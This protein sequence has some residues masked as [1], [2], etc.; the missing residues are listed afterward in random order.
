MK[1][2][3]SDS[4]SIIEYRDS[5]FETILLEDGH[6]FFLDMHLNRLRKAGKDILGLDLDITTIENFIKNN[7]PDKGIFGLRIV[8]SIDS[9][10]LSL[11]DVEYKESGFLDVSSQVRLSTDKK[12][13]YK[14]SDYKERLT[15]LKEVRS[16]GFLDTVYINEKGYVTSCSIANVYFLKAGVVYTPALE[17]GVLNGIVREI[18]LKSNDCIEGNFTIQD[19]VESEGMFISNSLMEIMKVNGIKDIAVTSNDDQLNKIKEQYFLEKQLDR[20]KCFG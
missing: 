4:R 15:E 9:C 18:I 8:C 5:I 6:P 3:L 11:R 7:I 14:T 16:K 19:F 13:R 2:E 10:F 1:Y 17:N 12:Y 20:R